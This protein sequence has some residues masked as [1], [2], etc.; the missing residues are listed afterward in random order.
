[1]QT[2]I[3]H[4]VRP[5]AFA[6]LVLAV[7]ILGAA[8]LAAQV[9]TAG[10]LDYPALPDVQIPQ[11]ERIELDN[12]MVVLL[13][14]DHEL[15]LVEARISLRAGSRLEP[16]D[17]I[18]LAQLTGDVL[19]TGGT[20]KI[21]GD[22]L[23]D[24][25]ENNAAVIETSIGETSGSAFLSSLSKDFSKMLDVFGDVLRHPVF[26]ESKLE[27]AK[28]QIV[29]GISRQNDNPSQIL[30]R[31]MEKLIYGEESPYARVETYESIGNI[32]RDDLIA[33]HDEYFRPERM[34]LGL[35]G[36]FDRDTALAEIRRVF[37][38][39][40]GDGKAAAAALAE[41]KTAEPETAEPGIYFVPKEDVTQSFV[42]MGHLGLRRDHPDYY[43]V[44]VMN[45]VLG[46]GFAA[47]LFSRVRSKKGLAY[48]VYGGV[49]SNWDY[50]GMAMLHI[51]TKT[52]T[53]GA[54]IEALL[55]EARGIQSEPPT[56][57][58]VRRAKEAIL[59]SFVFRSDSTS[60]ILGQQLTYETF[61][62]PLD[63]QERYR[64]GI[65]KVTL[66][67]VRAA[68]EHFDPDRFV[69]MV[70]GRSEGMD[71]PLSDFG[72]VHEVDITIP[73]P[74]AEAVEVTEEG[75]A[76]GAELLAKMVEH[77]G[78][79][80]IEAV[81]SL[82][83]RS[84]LELFLPQGAMSA[85]STSVI[86]FPNHFR[87]EIKMPFGTMVQVLAGDGGFMQGPQ[88]TQDLPPSALADLKKSLLRHPLSILRRSVG[89]HNS[90]ADGLTAV[91]IGPDDID[92]TAVERVHVDL[93]DAAFTLGIDPASGRLVSLDYRGQN[94]MG[95]PGE[96]RQTFGD[97]REIG[98]L[99]LPYEI[100]STFEGGPM[101]T[102]QV[103]EMVV[104]GE[105]DPALFVKP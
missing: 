54:G 77:V 63:W 20:T 86:L 101:V 84:R 59:G 14:E 33:F 73:E 27:I 70:V 15:P 29:S 60:K 2:Q 24:L 26:D 46:G 37:G 6:G 95:A 68:A 53:T 40:K 48:S 52:E 76:R 67:Q 49:Y 98:G 35:V 69:I 50:P 3:Q 93:D 66:E 105:V 25:L 39:W 47:R 78:G 18:G 44:E 4:L 96:I 12:G 89:V 64:Q 1:M 75:R 17:K 81:Q 36:D 8:P 23:D 56:D 43:A 16:E 10:E 58:E 11:P 92:G 87:Q 99:L 61:N 34:V 32:R 5:A 102:I 65:E 94:M 104:D 21:S 71:R 42:R 100:V 97:E 22:D 9:K 19:R 7:L 31:E 103:D 28:T 79:D 45:E 88:G 72:K 51:S 82:E 55:E 74:A 57:E 90:A 13:L 83:A 41:P 91:A 38:D 85:E 80:K 62:Y 30:G